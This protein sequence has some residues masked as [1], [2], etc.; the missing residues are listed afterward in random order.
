MTKTDKVIE[1][2]TG[3]GMIEIKSKSMKYRTFESPSSKRLYFV[4]KRGAVKTGKCS[5]K[6]F[7]IT[8]NVHKEM[9]K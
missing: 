7:S 2:L 6:S 8:S 3:K 9:N 1:F 4:G 5:S